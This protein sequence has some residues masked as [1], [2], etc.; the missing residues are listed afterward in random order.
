MPDPLEMPNGHQQFPSTHWSELLQLND[1]RHPLYAETLNA[2]IA[3]Y[4]KPAYH[5]VR[6]LRTVQVSEAMDLT[7]QFFT[8]LLARGDFERLTPE[9]GSF[10]G[11]LKT[12]LRNFLVSHDRS[13]AAR[14]PK[15]EAKLFHF[16]PSDVEWMKAAS[17]DAQDDPERAFDK[18][19]AQVVLLEAVEELERGLVARDKA[20]YFQ[21]FRAYCITPAGM[22]W[23]SV[24]IGDDG[25]P[26][27]PTYGELAAKYGVNEDAVRNYLRFARKELRDI[28]KSRVAAYLDPGADIER[29]LRFILSP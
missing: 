2:L 16:D 24:I 29:E 8:M 4:W 1:P 18:A 26:D 17:P 9:R 12:A 25:P 14:R 15:G 6:A 28:L 23:G 7:Q 5:Y 27:A 21:I 20:V 22:D 10:R 19:W 11:F 13:V 3:S